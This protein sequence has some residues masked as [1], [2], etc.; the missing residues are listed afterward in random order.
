L[1][2]GAAVNGVVTDWVSARECG[3]QNEGE[4]HRDVANK[5]FEKLDVHESVPCDVIIK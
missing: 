4:S 1:F 5:S 3:E 2:T